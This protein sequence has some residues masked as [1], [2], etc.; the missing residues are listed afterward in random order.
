MKKEM[1]M[2]KSIIFMVIAAGLLITSNLFSQQ[3][4]LIRKV[5]ENDTNAVKELVAAGADVNKADMSDNSPLKVACIEGHLEMAKLLI[6]KGADINM[7]DSWNGNTPLI[8]ACSKNHL[9]LAKYLI[10]KGADVNHIDKNESTALTSACRA[11]YLDIAKLLISEG[12]DIN[13]KH[14]NTGYTPLIGSC[15]YN[16]TD[17]T[18]FLLAEGADVNIRANDGSTALIHAAEYDL[19]IVNLLLSKGAD[20]NA[21]MNDGTSAF[22]KSILGILKGSDS[23]ELPEFFLSNGADVDEAAT[24]GDMVSWTPLF[25]AVSA[26]KENLV[27]FLIDN[28]ANVNA[29][30]KDVN[31]VL[32]LALKRGNDKIVEL[33]KDNGAK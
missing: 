28:G 8:W 10:S 22:S 4:D 7:Q 12:A 16:H 11:N 30:N 1:K 24:S 5:R 15:A 14:K 29:K 18:K 32:S 27:K 3:S 25:F 26:E 9:E 2:K 23:T 19:E 31:T 6:S 21:K 20:L 33:L 13:H 17:L